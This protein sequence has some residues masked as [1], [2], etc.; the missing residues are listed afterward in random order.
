MFQKITGMENFS[1]GS[2]RRREPRPSVAM[3][4]EVGRGLGSLRVGLEGRNEAPPEEH[5]GASEVPPRLLGRRRLTPALHRLGAGTGAGSAGGF[6]L[7][8]MPMWRGFGH[9]ERLGHPKNSRGI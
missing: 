1:V 8:E 7:Q 6:K 4:R 5:M 2:S 9:L 3:Q